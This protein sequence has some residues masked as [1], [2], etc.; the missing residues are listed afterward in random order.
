MTKINTLEIKIS[1]VQKYLRTL[2]KY[3]GCSVDELE[4]NEQLRGFIERYL[5][6]AAQSTIDLAEAFLSFKNF[7]RPTSLSDNFYILNEEEIIAPELVEKLIQMTGFRNILAHDYLKIDYKR[8]CD[9][10]KNDLKDIEKFVAIIAE[11]IK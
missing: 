7:R 6:L 5:Y 8:V 3:Q 4:N 1:T 9:I 10:L 2:K 11:K